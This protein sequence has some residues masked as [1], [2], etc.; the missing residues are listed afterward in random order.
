MMGV[1][2]RPAYRFSTFTIEIHQFARENASTSSRQP[3]SRRTGFRASRDSRRSPSAGRVGGDAV[4]GD[5]ALAQTRR[6]GRPAERRHLDTEHVI[7]AD[8]A[9]LDYPHSV[10]RTQVFSSFA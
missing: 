9:I 5:H 8:H 6:G 4:I 7:F 1:L 10:G 2:H 3:G